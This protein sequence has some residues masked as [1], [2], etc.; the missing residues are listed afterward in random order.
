MISPLTVNDNLFMKNQ[1]LFFAIVLASSGLFAQVGIGTTTPVASAALDVTSTTKGFLPPRMTEVQRDAIASPATGLQIYCIDCGYRGEPQY[2][3]GITWVNMTGA[4]AATSIWPDAHVH[5]N[6][7]SPTLTFDVLSPTGK[8]WMDRNLGA[9]RAATS[10]SDALS[11]GDLY[12]WGRLADG[13]QCRNSA[14]TSSLST[15]DSPGHGNFI[16]EDASPYDWRDPQENDLWQ[17][18]NG[19]NNPCPVGYRIPTA[20][21]IQDELSENNIN[22]A[23]DAFA[24]PLK[25]PAAG[26]RDRISGNVT[27]SSAG[28]YWTSTVLSAQVSILTFSTFSAIQPFDRANGFSVRCIKN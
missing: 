24:S 4:T 23:A 25:L 10:S 11:F 19:I 1:I 18:V 26:S 12:Q 5:C 21:E 7:S 27:V 9:S 3:N 14:T 16:I 8:T 22:N 2:F 13:H 15:T 6:S 20:A 28:Y 17:G